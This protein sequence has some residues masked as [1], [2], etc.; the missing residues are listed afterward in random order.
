[1]G[2]KAPSADTDF[3]GD[4]GANK[5]AV[6]KNQVVGIFDLVGFSRL[7]SNKDLVSAVR[8]METNIELALGD[9]YY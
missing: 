9:E 8:A 5:K 3:K 1:M 2:K 7:D 6:T 4:F